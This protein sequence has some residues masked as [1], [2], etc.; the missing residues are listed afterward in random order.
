MYWG[1]AQNK[2]TLKAIQLKNELYF[3][4]CSLKYEKR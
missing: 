3:W 4:E 1:Y 2:S